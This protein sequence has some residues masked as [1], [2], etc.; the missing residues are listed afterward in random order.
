MKPTRVT[1]I[2]ATLTDHIWTND[3]Q[4]HN[5][6]GILHSSPS[7]HFPALSSL[8]VSNTAKCSNLKTGKL[9]F[10]DELINKCNDDLDNYKWDEN[11][12]NVDA[13]EEFEKYLGNVLNL[14]SLSFPVKVYSKKE[15]CVGQPYITRA[16]QISIEQRNKLQEHY[17][18]WPVT[19]EAVLR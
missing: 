8:V 17:A 10:T 6:S 9:L 7:D 11:V 14:Y 12:N 15:K 18:T 13:N 3:S 5:N 1:N 19:Y 2:S 4:N 16:I